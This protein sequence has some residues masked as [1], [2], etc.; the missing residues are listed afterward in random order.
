MAEPHSRTRSWL[1][2]VA[3]GF[4]IV[5]TIGDMADDGASFWNWLTLLVCGGFLL[6][7]IYNLT[8]ER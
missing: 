8:S 5:V 6:Q 1:F 7:Q 3:F 2:L 4:I